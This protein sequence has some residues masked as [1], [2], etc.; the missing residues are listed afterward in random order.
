[1]TS[2]SVRKLAAIMFT[3]MVGYTA[4][5]Q[6]DEA[7]ARL[8][9][10]RHRNVLQT[11][12]QQCNGEIIQYYGD[13]TLSIFESA[14]CAVE[15]AIEIQRKLSETPQVPL[16][17][18]IH[19]GEVVQEE[20]G[21][22]GDGVNVASR[23]ESFS[24]PGAVLVTDSVFQQIQNQRHLTTTSLGHFLFKN[25]RRPVEI[26]ALT[27]NGLVIPSRN[28]LQGKGQSYDTAR[29]NLPHQLTSFIG[30]SEEIRE[31]CE[32][33]Q[34][35]RLITLTGPGGTG[36]TRLALKV[37]ETLFSQFRHGLYWVPLA[38]VSEVSSV[39]LAIAKALDLLQDPSKNMLQQLIEF[40]EQKETLL[41]LDNF[42][43]IVDAAPVVRQ[44]LAQ[45]ESVKILVT[46]RIVL[47]LQ[48][49][50][51]FP[52]QPFRVPA[53][54]GNQTP[55]Y[56]L[57]YPS[58]DLF[59]QRARA[60]NPDFK[61]NDQNLA[62]IA[63]ICQRLDGL[64]LAI[65]LAAARIK[66]FSPD[67]LLKRLDHHLDLLKAEGT[68]RPERHQTL[69]QAIKWSYE[70]LPL[71]EKILFHRL[72]IFSGGCDLEAI[73]SICADSH[74]NQYEIV[75]LVLSLV[76]KSLLN[77]KENE[78]G[79]M[80]FYMLETIRAFSFESLTSYENPVAIQKA[81]AVYFVSK[82]EKAQPFLTGP[83]QA[84]WFASLESDLDNFR[85]AVHWAIKN[86]EFE[87]AFRIGI[88]L[89][90]L[91][92]S[93][94]MLHEGVNMAQRLLD[95][96]LSHE[97]GRLKVK[98][99]EGL[100]ATYFYTGDYPLTL[101][102]CR[103]NLAFWK[104]TGDEKEIAINMNHLGFG[105]INC[106]F[107]QEG[108]RVTRQ[109]LEIHKILKDIR[110]QAVSLN[111]LG[112][113]YL[114][115]GIPQE[116]CIA[117][118]QSLHLRTSIKDERGI[119]FALINLARAKSI[120]G[121]YREALALF[122]QGLSMLKEN[123]EKVV[124][125]WGIVNQTLLHYEMGN[126]DKLVKMLQD[127]SESIS[128]TN[129]I[130][131]LKGWTNFFKG[132]LAEYNHSFQEAHH[133]LQQGT[134][135]FEERQMFHYA[136]KG[137]YYRSIVASDAGFPDEAWM[138]LSTSLEINNRFD[139]HLGLAENFEFAGVLFA[140]AGELEK[141]G[142]L[143]SKARNLRLE[144]EAPTPPVMEPYVLN[145]RNLIE[146]GLPEEKLVNTTE[147]GIQMSVNEALKLFMQR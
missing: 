53:M 18:G 19:V 47:Q 140:R 44:I 20:D 95:C 124:S 56:L 72:S 108:I 107:I 93:R 61:L 85:E 133:W 145:V 66:I 28:E 125:L 116:A 79:E 135:I 75:D 84:Y 55:E 117:L 29:N 147:V 50:Q 58:V 63:S 51:E 77:R 128:V 35:S 49:E 129:L 121:H 22:Y 21:I 130:Y 70:L 57:Q 112:W 68:D 142:L 74:S 1:M 11:A 9:R 80:R 27:N 109:A 92:V 86:Q 103:E 65:E 105:L 87:L 89:W 114:N 32:L 52:V 104:A 134:N 100:I 33:F 83:E 31:I 118:E 16:R 82:A 91:W 76:N 78:Q 14:V 139:F 64:P 3:D 60:V 73:E 46:S 119:G 88:A 102:L 37:A 131:I 132:L 136:S 138:H 127:T 113:A 71:A 41:I 25:V 67:A 34:L 6:E 2:S 23:V 30:R 96:Q 115:K 143:L 69:R 110:G 81:H 43:Q 122:D 94:G 97:F 62:T 26:F 17:I 42:E 45:C 8:K 101:P 39:G 99:V 13:G 15:C 48:G 40:L 36:K 98:I 144:L 126:I 12:H 123:K 10:E 5:M 111:N 24:V 106:G 4:L 7:L 54:N 38:S 90:R 120:L 137:W 141:A 146:T 59:Y